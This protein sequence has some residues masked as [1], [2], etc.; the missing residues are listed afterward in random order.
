[1]YWTLGFVWW[2]KYVYKKVTNSDYSEIWETIGLWTAF[3]GGPFC[4]IHE[5][6]SPKNTNN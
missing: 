1:M 5:W 4:L 6:I 3:L 2:R